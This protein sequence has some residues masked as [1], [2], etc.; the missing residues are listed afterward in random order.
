MK[1]GIRRT[2]KPG[3]PLARNGQTV[4]GGTFLKQTPLSSGRCRAT[5]DVPYTLRCVST[6]GHRGDHMDKE[7]N[8]WAK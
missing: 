4:M 6:W 3:V 2:R 5:H 8:T 7:G 1:Q